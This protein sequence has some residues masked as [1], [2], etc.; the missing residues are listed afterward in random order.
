MLYEWD[1]QKDDENLRKH[2]LRL[3]DGIPAIEGPAAE[4]WIDDRYE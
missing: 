2:D 4:F 1:S 3:G